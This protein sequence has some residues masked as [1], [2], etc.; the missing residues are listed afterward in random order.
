MAKPKGLIEF[1]GT[2][3][4]ITSYTL[5]GKT[6]LR[7]C[8]GSEKEKLRTGKNHERTRENMMEFSG[9]VAAAKVV[10]QSL[11]SVARCFSDPGFTGR[12]Q[13]KYRD[14][15]NVSSGIR[16]QRVFNPLEHAEAICAIPFNEELHLDSVLRVK[17]VIIANTERTAT[18]LSLSLNT[19]TDIYTPTGATHAELI[20]AI[21]VQPSF[22]YDTHI[23]KYNRTDGL[24]RHYM[25]SISSTLIPVH[26]NETMDI[27]LSPQPIDIT[28]LHA[29][30]ALVSVLGI[31]FHQQI[32][33]KSYPLET[34]KAMGIVA[35]N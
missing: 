5:N 24:D 10:R 34:G 31:Q 9:A 20:Y 11:A 7:Q 12:L 33:F 16:G 2:M 28:Q 32:G 4:G 6:V 21:A 29:A 25:Q 19:A 27:S 22:E 35:V 26:I 8:R 30:S 1:E 13:G 15:I 23:K 18:N 3:G 14:M 17:P